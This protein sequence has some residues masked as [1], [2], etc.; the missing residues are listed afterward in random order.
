MSNIKVVMTIYTNFLKVGYV[1]G[2]KSRVKVFEMKH[3]KEIS[4]EC[5]KDFII[6]VRETKYGTRSHLGNKGTLEAAEQ[7]ERNLILKAFL[8]R[9]ICQNIC[10]LKSSASSK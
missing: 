7:G 2:D 4:C 5:L 1:D 8:A 9:T 10:F 3:F 6:V